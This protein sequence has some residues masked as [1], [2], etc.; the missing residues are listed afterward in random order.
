MACAVDASSPVRWTG[1]Y[2]VGAGGTITSAAFTAPT[3]ALLVLCGEVD[4]STGVAALPPGNLTASDS[5]GL[6]WT[7]RV[8]R[9]GSETTAGGV[10]IIFTARTTSSVSRTVNVI[11]ANVGAGG[12]D[13][14]SGRASAKLYVVTG[15]DVNG[16][17]VDA[18]TAANEGGDTT[19]NSLTTTALTPGANGLLFAADCE[20][21]ERGA[22]DASSN[23]T[24]DTTTY[25]SQ[26]SV[27]DGYRTVTSGVSATANLNAGGA[28]APQHKWVQII[29]REA[30]SALT[31]A[32]QSGIW[33]QLLS[34]CVIGRCDA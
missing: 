9:A 29:V 26:V 11:G 3:D 14:G 21:N 16:T 4:S 33:D 32:Q 7:T 15:A 10:S 27:C 5:G 22:F 18:V 6:V 24:Q 28:L 25:A 20:W 1:L 2:G 8:E 30:A 17:P 31:A 23:L 12:V 19:N 34:G 13:Y